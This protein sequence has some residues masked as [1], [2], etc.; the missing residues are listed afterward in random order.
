MF[1]I[2][3]LPKLVPLF[4]LFWPTSVFR[5]QRMLNY[6][7][8]KPNLNTALSFTASG[9]IRSML[10]SLQ[11]YNSPLCYRANRLRLTLY[12]DIFEQCSHGS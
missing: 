4:H 10:H 6:S 1:Y 9:T 2:L 8:M 11:R 7:S 5:R 3:S 12:L